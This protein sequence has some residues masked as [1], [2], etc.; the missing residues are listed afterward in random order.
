MALLPRTMIAQPF[1]FSANSV[2]KPTVGGV[3]TTVTVPA[4]MWCRTY[5]AASGASGATHDV[6]KEFLAY[7]EGLIETASTAAWTIRMRTDGRVEIACADATWS[8]QFD[9][10]NGTDAVVGNLL[11]YGSTNVT[12]GAGTYATATYQPTHCVYLVART[13]DNGW[14]TEP[15]DNAFGKLPTGAVYE[16]SSGY[17][18]RSRQFDSEIHPYTYGALTASDVAATPVEAARSRWLQ[19]TATPSATLTP[20]WSVL[21]TVYTCGG[22]EL[23][24]AADF[25]DHVAAST[26]SYDA[27]YLDPE[28]RS[29]GLVQLQQANWN[30]ARKLVGWRLTYVGQETRS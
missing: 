20:P 19:P 8:L 24:F 4:N 9:G 27:V 6:P 18:P 25:Q 28:T 12:A 15:M 26:T 23:G 3:T 13:N 1:Q 11:G 21:D 7:L 16:F 14:V 5:L 10:T 22:R 30:K 17:A 2:L 29:R